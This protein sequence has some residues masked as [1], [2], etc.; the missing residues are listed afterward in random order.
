MLASL[1]TQNCTPHRSRR[2]LTTAVRNAEARPPARLEGRTKSALE[3]ATAATIRAFRATLLM[4]FWTRNCKI[5]I[6]LISVMAAIS[7]APSFFWML[8]INAR[9]VLSCSMIW[10]ISFM[11]LRVPGAICRLAFHSCKRWSYGSI[12][13]KPGERKFVAMNH[14]IAILPTSSSVISSPVRS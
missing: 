6:E 9:V 2:M 3:I 14:Y 4:D 11:C 13:E 5:S 8:R 10:A 12:F 1:G 7:P